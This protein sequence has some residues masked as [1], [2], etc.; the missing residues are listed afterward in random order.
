MFLSTYINMYKQTNN[1]KQAHIYIYI[2]FCWV[3]RGQSLQL[4][5]GSQI[6]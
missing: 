1:Y 5:Q 2:Y 6:E 3:N 4:N